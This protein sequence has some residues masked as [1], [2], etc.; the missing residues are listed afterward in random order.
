MIEQVIVRP[1]PSPHKGLY[2]P[3]LL[4]L[5]SI[6]TGLYD[7]EWGEWNKGTKGMDPVQDC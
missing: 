1:S 7:V 6:I 5:K 2:G 4:I 3:T